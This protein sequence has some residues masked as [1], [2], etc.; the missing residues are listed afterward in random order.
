MEKSAERVMKWTQFLMEVLG[1]WIVL[2]IQYIFINVRPNSLSYI[3]VIMT[4]IIVYLFL[5]GILKN[6]LVIYHIYLIAPIIFVVSSLLHFETYLAIIMSLFIC[7]RLDKHEKEPDM[8]N[9]G[10]VLGT[11][12]GFTSIAYLISFSNSVTFKNDVFIIFIIQFTI[13][14]VGK[15]ISYYVFD[16]DRGQIAKKS[17]T[18]TTIL[19][20][21]FGGTAM[22][23]AFFPA[24][25]RMFYEGYHLLASL[26]GALFG[27]FFNLISF[28]SRRMYEENEEEF[29]LPEE[30]EFTENEY[31]E[32]VDASAFLDV[33]TTI[34]SIVIVLVAI[35][36]IYK[37]RDYFK[38][39]AEDVVEFKYNDDIETTK[40]R[41]RKWGFRRHR[42]SPPNNEVRKAFY[43][44]EL[45]AAK[46]KVGRFQFESIEDWLNRYQLNH[47]VEDEVIEVY[48]NVRY[49]QKDI[50]QSLKRNY[51]QQI[52]QL[53]NEL[54]L[55]KENLQDEANEL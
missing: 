33:M 8:D 1:L 14:L 29:E 36:V 18:V 20:I 7:W 26:V 35:Y 39:R 53:K 2:Y 5:K 55:K 44:L 45:W 42:P 47:L 19:A 46:E 15:W 54:K 27:G 48:R 37:L 52:E 24:I 43:K 28:E 12:L 30:L 32:P 25:R 11:S 23:Y 10:L 49:G 38:T 40:V 22:L 50:N 3:V 31:R 17:F 34:F 13:F 4:A 6:K 21:L 16:P 41:N 51:L 9:E